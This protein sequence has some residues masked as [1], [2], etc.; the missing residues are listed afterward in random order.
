MSHGAHRGGRAARRGERHLRLVSRSGQAPPSITSLRAGGVEAAE[1]LYD[2]YADEVHSL[3]WHLLGADRDHDD[4]VQ[5]VFYQLLKG[6]ARVRDAAALRGWVRSVTVNTVRS[7]LRKRSLRRL[8]RAAPVDE[9]RF[10][11][12]ADD[13]EARALLCQVYGILEGLSPRLRAV[14]VLRY[15]EQL[16]LPEVASAVGSS[17]ATVK[18]LLKRADRLFLVAARKHEGLAERIAAGARWEVRD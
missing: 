1:L 12:M 2:R 15:V 17:L 7:H 5:E 4:L 8:F 18:R 13:P 6:V 14:F 10:G 9:D 3:V 11:Q 16:T